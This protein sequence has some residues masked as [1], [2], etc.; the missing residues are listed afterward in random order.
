V[1]ADKH[2]PSEKEAWELVVHAL[3]AQHGLLLVAQA[4][5]AHARGGAHYRV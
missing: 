5:C 1:L 2:T 4:V 3:R